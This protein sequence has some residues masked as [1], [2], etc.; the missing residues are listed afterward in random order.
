MAVLSFF[1]QRIDDWI[2]LRNP[3]TTGKISLHNRRLYILPTRFGY[4]YAIMQ[5][6]LLLAAIN[7]QNSMAYV[8]TFLLTALGIISLWQ[9]HK[10]LLGLSIQLKTPQPVFQQEE[11]VLDFVISHSNLVDRYAIGIQ[12]MNQP[13]I[14]ISLKPE[15]SNILSLSLPAVKRGL[16]KPAGFIIFT[17]YPTGLFHAWSVLNYE[18]PVLIYPKPLYDMKLKETIA[19]EQH[20]KSTIDTT[21]GDD[22]AGLREYH[23]GESL[24]HISW[25]AYA[26][27][28][29]MLTKTFQGHA[30]PALW[31]NW[32]DM[33]ASSQE[34]K[35]S[36]MTALVIQ[37]NQE[38]RK[39]GIKLPGVEIA[40]S[41]GPAHLSEC[42]QQISIYKQSELN[43]VLLVDE[44]VD[45]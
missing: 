40:Q 30:S 45:Q 24:K 14:Y 21:D 39:F 3:A 44:H 13:P 15:Q 18:I 5:V 33:T 23:Q 29:G 12:Y 4:L 35:L 26:Q 10:N 32:F 31:I 17:R 38:G 8:L 7:Y 37:T 11:L 25:K 9:T 20:C 28:R 43:S 27:G 22:F 16:Y 41:A 42:L 2:V 19:D 1:Q 34:G 36:Q 6:V